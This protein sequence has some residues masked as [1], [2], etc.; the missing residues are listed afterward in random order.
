MCDAALSRAKIGPQPCNLGLWSE[1]TSQQTVFVQPLQPLRIAD[2]RLPS[3][4][5]LG[6]TGIDH[7]DVKS[8]LFQN[9]EDGDPIDPSRIHGDRLDPTASEPVCQSFQVTGK[10]TERPHRLFV[11]IRTDGR[12]MHGSADIDRCCSRM[13]RRPMPWRARLLRLR[14]AVSPPV[15]ISQRGAG[16]RSTIN[17]LIGIARKRHHLQVRN[18]PWTTF[19]YGDRSTKKLSAAPLHSTI[20][21]SVSTATGGPPIRARF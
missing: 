7:H 2:V 12:D 20:A 16:R 18:R 5:V 13:N 3:R 4:H 15:G 17:F 21:R 11:A 1:A 10:S 19:F 14:H 8:A 9:L 6:V